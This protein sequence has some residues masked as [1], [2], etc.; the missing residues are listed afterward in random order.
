MKAR[1]IQNEPTYRLVDM[2]GND[3]EVPV[4]I[5]KTE[6]SLLIKKDLT[7]GDARDVMIQYG[8]EIINLNEFIK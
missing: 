6:T 1:L 8:V 7:M 3:L 4:K 5:G 2:N